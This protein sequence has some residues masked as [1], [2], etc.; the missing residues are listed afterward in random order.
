MAVSEDKLNAFLGKAVA[1]PGAAISAVLILLG[2][3]SVFTEN[4]PRDC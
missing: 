3:N 1:V 4:W 2:D